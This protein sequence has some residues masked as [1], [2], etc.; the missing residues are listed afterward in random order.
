MEEKHDKESS[1]ASK[2]G[3]KKLKNK[4]L[5]Y[6]NDNFSN[7]LS[8]EHWMYTVIF[9][10]GAFVLA[11][12]SLFQGNVAVL[13]VA[14]FISTIL[15]FT[16]GILFVLSNMDSFREKIL[17]A[18]IKKRAIWLLISSGIATG[19]FI[20]IYIPSLS[21]PDDFRL[22][23]ILPISYML[24]FFG[25]NFIQIFFIRKGMETIST[26]VENWA[27]QHAKNEKEETSRS[28]PFLIIGI[29]A[30]VAFFV[31]IVIIF[32]IYPAGTIASLLANPFGIIVLSLWMLG[33]GLLLTVASLNLFATHRMTIQ[34]GTPT[35][36]GSLLHMFFWIYV[37]YR[38][39]SFIS[40]TNNFFAG[41][42]ALSNLDKFIDILL[43]LASLFLLFK[44]L[45]NKLKRSS[46]FNKDN[47]PFIAYVFALIVVMGRISLVLGIPSSGVITPLSQSLVAAMNNLLM[48]SVAIVFYFL[49]F[50]PKLEELNYVEKDTY[51]LHEVN[52]LLDD[53]RR[54][55]V[56]VGHISGEQ[57]RSTLQEFL[58]D[59]ELV[60]PEDEETGD[61]MRPARQEKDKDTPITQDGEVNTDVESGRTGDGDTGDGNDTPN[62]SDQDKYPMEKPKKKNEK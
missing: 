22:E 60:L 38:S 40:A 46:F 13:T 12:L 2:P 16:F 61:G 39:Y 6:F 30:P 43:M 3:S 8:N 24:V 45:G 17:H 49:Y 44:G 50:K 31:T 18:S 41:V 55:M 11:I 9:V 47:L 21:L 19:I 4:L 7:V 15:A 62:P 58:K 5:D 20:S 48:M 37:V 33:I 10:L 34:H 56:H 54:R 57:G 1:T 42:D 27:F 35:I 32:F 53:F 14:T 51:T 28:Y 36:F 29:F 25:W 26:K 52:E 59:H 23:I